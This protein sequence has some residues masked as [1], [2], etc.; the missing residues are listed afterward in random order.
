[1]FP[2]QSN[3]FTEQNLKLT[4]TLNLIRRVEKPAHVCF[5]CSVSSYWRPETANKTRQCN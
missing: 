1:M 2:F 4:A 3:R 5:L